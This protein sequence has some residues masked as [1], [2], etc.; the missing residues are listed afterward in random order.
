MP[1]TRRAF[2]LAAV[3]GYSLLPLSGHA[4]VAQFAPNGL[5]KI[6]VPYPPGGPVDS[7]GRYTAQ[8]L[9]EL[10]KS[11]VVVENRSGA[12]G[13]IGT[14]SVA[15]APPDGHTL[16]MAA[17]ASSGSAEVLN[18]K[19]VPYRTLR[20]FSMLGFIGVSPSLLVVRADIP[21]RTGKE[22]VEL[23]LKNPGKYSYASTSTG[24]ASA[25]AFEMLKHATGADIVQI[26]Y[27]GAGPALI[28]LGGGHVDGYIAG[29]F[30]VLP[31]VQSGKARII[32]AASEQRI[33]AY[34]DLPTLRE[35]GI[36]SA[37]DTWFGLLAPAGVPEDVLNKL[38]ADMM[39]AL[40]GEEARAALAKQG[41]E[42][43]LG[44]RAVMRSVVEKEIAEATRIGT[45]A[46]MIQN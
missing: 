15:G 12:G 44:S 46:K 36:A 30:T 28:A 34:P 7:I 43:R 17:G 11:P 24:S 35:Q 1:I 8:R 27:N 3:A 23:A 6:I 10:W 39:T 29:V 20:D 16:L 5:V 42:R 14:H 4:R 18:P 37:W 25:F 9:S 13:V 33:Q 40:D 19:T 45:F 38:N 21:A 31:L 2:N 22:F 26:P 32:G 41:L